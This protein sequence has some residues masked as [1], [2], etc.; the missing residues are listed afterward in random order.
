MQQ[1]GVQFARY[2]Q[3]PGQGAEQQLTIIK[4]QLLQCQAAVAQLAIQGQVDGSVAA[5]QAALPGYFQ[6]RQWALRGQ[7]AVAQ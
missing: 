5:G 1:A 2:G 3:I 4:L 7:L 6:G